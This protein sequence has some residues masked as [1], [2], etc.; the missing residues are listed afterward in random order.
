[1]DTVPLPEGI[2]NETFVALFV[3]VGIFDPFTVTVE[4]LDR[5]DPVMVTGVFGGPLDGLIFVIIGTE[6]KKLLTVLIPSDKIK[7][8]LVFPAGI[9]VVIEVADTIVNVREDVPMNTVK[10]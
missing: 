5:V 7:E 4:I 3:K 2:V 8:L 6:T 9:V 1:M 10:I